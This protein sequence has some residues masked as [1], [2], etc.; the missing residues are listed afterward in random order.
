MVCIISSLLAFVDCMHERD[1]L[2]GQGNYQWPS[3]SGLEKAEPSPPQSS[4]L[5]DLRR[6]C[7]TGNERLPPN[8]SFSEPTEPPTTHSLL[9]R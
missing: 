1:W 3:S 6:R 9:A 8:T 7:Q 2:L 5:K 4:W